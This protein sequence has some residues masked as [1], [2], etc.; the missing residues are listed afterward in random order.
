M[1]SRRRLRGYTLIEFVVAIAVFG[2]FLMILTSLTMQ[3]RRSEKTLPVNFMRHPQIM[4]VLARM[5]RDVLDA[6][7]AD[8]YREEF[9]GYTQSPKTLIIESVQESGGVQTIIWDFRTPGE[10]LRRSY[11][12][13]V[14]TNWVARGLPKEF[15][16]ELVVDAVGIPGRPWGVRLTARDAEG[17]LAIDQILQ[18]RAHE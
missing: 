2:V 5:R 6:H 16:N 17:R 10:V 9:D 11:N 14:G 13:G 4:S 1:V 12:V 18:P 15:S 7:G 8:P 3:M